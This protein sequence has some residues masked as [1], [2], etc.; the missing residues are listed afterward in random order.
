MRFFFF[1]FENSNIFLLW[2]IIHHVQLYLMNR[3]IPLFVGHPRP[4]MGNHRS[5]GFFFSSYLRTFCTI[6]ILIITLGTLSLSYTLVQRITRLNKDNNNN[7]SDDNIHIKNPLGP[8]VIRGS[9]L[10]DPSMVTKDTTTDTD[11]TSTVNDLSSSSSSY[12]SSSS[13]TTTLKNI[14]FPSSDTT[15]SNDHP[16]GSNSIAATIGTDYTVWKEY[17]ATNILP[18]GNIRRFISPS[19]SLVSSSCIE[20]A[21]SPSL[22]TEYERLYSKPPRRPLPLPSLLPEVLI[23][24]PVKNSR[25]HLD[26]YF[27]LLHNLSYPSCKLS[28][29]MLDSDSTDTPDTHSVTILQ[30]MGYTDDEISTMSGTLARLLAEVP[31]LLQKGWSSV[32]IITHDFHFSLPRL[33]R[34]GKEVQLLRRSMLARARNHLVSSALQ[35]EEWTLWVDSDLHTYASNTLLRLI[36]ATLHKPIARS[37]TTSSSRSTDPTPGDDEEDDKTDRSPNTKDNNGSPS[38]PLFNTDLD[39]NIL[40]SSSINILVPNCVLD[41]AY[42]AGQREYRRSYDLNSWRGP[43]A[44]GNNATVGQVVRYHDKI[45]KEAK[46]SSSTTL[47]LEGYG[48]TGAKYLHQLRSI[49]PGSSNGGSNGNGGGF[50]TYNQPVRLDGVGGAML[51]IKSELHRHGLIFPPMVYRHRIETE[52]LA[53]MALDMGILSWGIPD[54]EIVHK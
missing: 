38:L 19:S 13:F 12:S 4:G 39:R 10:V 22:V 11:S 52:G 26:R 17:I 43:G 27:R 30:Y 54:L 21:S 51:M 28:L 50:V 42:L 7:P 6:L 37:S 31:K 5:K 44:P 16:S 20:K 25:N 45:D 32:T 2:G 3:G 46:S 18:R 29:G 14:F 40:S 36:S 53:M 1:F 47:W 23:L 33:N 24:T 8:T 35:N 9:K 49:L 41:G 48:S 15:V 34:H